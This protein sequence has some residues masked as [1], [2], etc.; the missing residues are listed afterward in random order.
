LLLAD[1]DDSEIGEQVLAQAEG[2]ADRG[3]AVTVVGSLTRREQERLGRRLIRWAR[4]ELAAEPREGAGRR[5]ADQLRRLL[6]GRAPDVVHAHG[7]LPLA[8]ATGAGAGRLFHVPPRLVASLYGV[9][10]PSSPWGRWRQRRSLRPLLLA[11]SRVLLSSQ[12]DREALAALAG[13]LSD[14][15]EI[16]YPTVLPGGRA[17]GVETGLLRRRL[18][19]SGHAAVI[20]FVTTFTD[21]EF[22]I[23]LQAAGQVQADLPN[24][25][26][27]FL[28]DGPLREAAEQAAHQAGL[29]GACVFL[30]RPRSVVE[31]LRVLNALVVLS[32]AGAAHLHALQ[33][34]AFGMPVI[35]ARVGALG[36]LLEA[37]PLA[38]LLAPGDIAGLARALTVALHTIPSD[39]TLADREEEAGPGPSIEQ[40]LVSRDYWD[41]DQPWRPGATR[42]VVR[43]PALAA[44]L[45]RFQP[46]VVLDRLVEIY[47][48]VL[49]E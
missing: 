18:G 33:A 9:P 46:Q 2:L 20:G 19:L 45:A 4:L 40:F 12:A 16:L 5:A 25:E 14:R 28:G 43:Q 47:A 29:G 17:S 8:V 49:A 15:M 35:A 34:L 36:E 1:F 48:H 7:Y 23:F 42:P 6:A 38:H 13:P 31:T 24:V 21:R 22:E 41:L 37:V 39:S 30:G 3:V 32:D 11:C 10:R 44:G 26:F 27:A